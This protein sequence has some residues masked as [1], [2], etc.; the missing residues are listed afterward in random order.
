MGRPLRIEFPGATY[1]ITS[2]GDRQ[3]PIFKDDID[4]EALI[5]VMGGAMG[6]LDAEAFAFCLMGNHYH[7]VVHTRQANLSRLMRQINGQYT[8]AFNRRHGVTG[9]VFQGRFHSVLV[10]SDAYLVQVC[11]YVELNPV[12]A[13]LVLRA[14]QWPWSSFRTN[15]GQSHGFSWLA[16]LTLHGYLMGFDIQTDEHRMLASRRY[17]ETVNFGKDI[18]LWKDHLRAEIYLGDEAF[19][20]HTKA[21]ATQQ[22]LQCT[23]ISKSHRMAPTTLATWLAPGRSKDEAY[24]LA[25]CVGGMNM[26]QIAREAGLSI[27]AVSRKIANAERLQHSRPDTAIFKT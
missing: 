15:S 17:A 2:R 20:Q 13:G 10:D 26:A 22:R 19:V 27:S 16:T 9:H 4:R 25:Y 23:E 12:K 8:R 14:E 3:E 5:D 18:A 7:L 21:R 6:R 11:R 1:H 24:R